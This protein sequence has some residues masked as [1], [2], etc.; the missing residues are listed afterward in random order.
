[1]AC[2]LYIESASS[3][4]K[5]CASSSC[6]DSGSSTAN[7][8]QQPHLPDRCA[9]QRH[10]QTSRRHRQPRPTTKQLRLQPLWRGQ[11]R[12]A[13]SACK[14]EALARSRAALGLPAPS[15]RALECATGFLTRVAR[16]DA[17]Q[18]PCCKHG[19]LRVVKSLAGKKRLH[20]PCATVVLEG[21]LPRGRGPP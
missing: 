13:A 1:M 17:Q 3:P 15:P 7:A 14:G 5:T 16:V 18:C 11:H 8:C 19:R 6:F 10:S 12:G 2:L 4:R 20:E 9:Q 21:V